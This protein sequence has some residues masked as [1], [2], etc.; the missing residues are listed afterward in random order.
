MKIN[1]FLLWRSGNPWSKRRATAIAVEFEPTG[2]NPYFVHK[3]NFV[4]AMP[5]HAIASARKRCKIE[6]IDQTQLAKIIRF[7]SFVHASVTNEC[8]RP[9][10]SFRPKKA[11]PLYRSPVLNGLTIPPVVGDKNSTTV[12]PA[13]RKRRLKGTERE[14]WGISSV[15]YPQEEMR[16]TRGWECCA[17]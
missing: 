9:Y 4:A 10:P 13:C 8:S 16:R 11:R 15:F 1:V 5:C 7:N 12:F 14:G 6:G 2:K 3:F 17:S